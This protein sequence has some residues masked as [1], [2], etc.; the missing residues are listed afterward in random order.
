MA[1]MT[2]AQREWR[3]GQ[4]KKR[5]S[6]RV[7]FAST[8]LTLEAFVALFATLGV[9]GLYRDRIAPALTLTVGIA[10]AV[11]CVL[12]CALLRRPLGYWIG[13]AIQLILILAGFIEPLMFVVGI[14][15]AATWW[16]AVTKGR[17]MDLENARRDREQELWEAENPGEP[18]ADA[19][20]GAR[21][22]GRP[23]AAGPDGAAGP[24]AGGAPPAH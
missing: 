9:F 8:V 3:P 10:L 19:S 4:K 13:W 5:R 1:R 16:Y 17:S 18:A 7:M 6:V 23:G 21:T 24:P 22:K 11:V 20:G 2:K 15:F 14:L 12:A